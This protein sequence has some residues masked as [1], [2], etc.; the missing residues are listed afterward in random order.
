MIRYLENVTN[1]ALWF[2]AYCGGELYTLYTVIKK[3]PAPGTRSR[4]GACASG[5]RR[6]I[7][8]LPVKE[9]RLI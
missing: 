6:A 2:R 3:F 9:P 5:A 4:L 8:M 7:D 1:L